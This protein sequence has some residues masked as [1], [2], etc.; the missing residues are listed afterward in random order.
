MLDDFL[1][2]AAA[3]KILGVTS[4]Q[5]RY[6]LEDETL[7]GSQ[8]TP[9]MW[10]VSKESVEALKAKRGGNTQEQDNLK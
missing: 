3:A 2:T 7:Q 8:I 6:W 1:T 10:L 4:R 5:I 9:R